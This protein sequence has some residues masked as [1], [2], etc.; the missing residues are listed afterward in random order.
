MSYA[1]AYAV[2]LFVN[3]KSNEDVRKELPS[4]VSEMVKIIIQLETQLENRKNTGFSMKVPGKSI[5]KIITLSALPF[6]LYLTAQNSQAPRRYAH[7][8]R[9]MPSHSSQK[10]STSHI[11]IRDLQDLEACMDYVWPCC[12]AT[13]SIHKTCL[14]PS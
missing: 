3:G 14:T 6:A 4:A 12:L 2:F 8:Y 1:V 5:E 13:T 11:P 7:S 9:K 10:D